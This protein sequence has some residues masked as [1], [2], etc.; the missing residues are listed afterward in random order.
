MQEVYANIVSIHND[1]H[2]LAFVM[3]RILADDRLI[4]KKM[5]IRKLLNLLKILNF[6]SVALSPA[7]FSLSLVLFRL[8]L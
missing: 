6:S 8:V 3:D 4:T 7:Q 5:L 1:E 2:A